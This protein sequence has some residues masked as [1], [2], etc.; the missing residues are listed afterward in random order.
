MRPCVRAWALPIAIAVIVVA[1]LAASLALQAAGRSLQ[2]ADVPSLAYWNAA[3]VI[4]TL[5]LIA[6]G[7]LLG[8]RQSLR[9]HAGQDGVGSDRGLVPVFLIS[10]VVVIYDIALTILPEYYRLILHDSPVRYLFAFLAPYTAGRAIAA[11]LLG[12]TGLIL[13]FRRPSG[14]DASP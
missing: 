11:V 6:L 10:Q 8:Y 2:A 14:R 9:D 13:W 3:R 4:P 1:G 7:A 5:Q 12:Y